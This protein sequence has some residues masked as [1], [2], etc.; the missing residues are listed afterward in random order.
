MVQYDD[1]RGYD[2]VVLREVVVVI[3]VD[4]DRLWDSSEVLKKLPKNVRLPP[5]FKQFKVERNNNDVCVFG[6]HDALCPREVLASFGP[7]CSIVLK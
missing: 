3:P 6:G 2:V 4:N 5:V 7:G 1:V